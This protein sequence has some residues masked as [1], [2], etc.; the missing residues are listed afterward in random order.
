MGY[1]RTALQHV[2]SLSLW[3]TW[4]L[5]SELLITTLVCCDS[6]L[7]SSPRK[8]T[9]AWFTLRDTSGRNKLL[10]RRFGSQPR[11]VEDST[12]H[13]QARRLRPS[14]PNSS[15][16]LADGRRFPA[17][18]HGRSALICCQGARTVDAWRRLTRGLMTM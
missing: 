3:S 8:P 11:D 7:L 10:A 17:D 9:N 4:Q 14:D 2:F 1:I 18:I 13:D 6:D 16:S 15:R 12:S 5:Q